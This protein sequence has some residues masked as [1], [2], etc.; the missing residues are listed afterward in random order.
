MESLDQQ[1]YGRKRKPEGEEIDDR[2][3]Q[4]L[5]ARMAKLEVAT[6]LMIGDREFKINENARAA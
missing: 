4:R 1:E 3:A 6:E 2:P 5:R